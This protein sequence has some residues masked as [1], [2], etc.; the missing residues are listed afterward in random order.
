MGS[1]AFNTEKSDQS[2]DKDDLKKQKYGNYVFIT[3]DYFDFKTPIE[4]NKKDFSGY[5]I[6]EKT[7]TEVRWINSAPIH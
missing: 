2:K 1:T 6:D 3:A 7:L 4:V 5:T